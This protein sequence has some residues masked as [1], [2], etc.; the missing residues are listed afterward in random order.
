MLNME[1]SINNF[2]RTGNQETMRTLSIVT[3]NFMTHYILRPKIS[4]IK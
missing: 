2:L 4:L 1:E 3:K